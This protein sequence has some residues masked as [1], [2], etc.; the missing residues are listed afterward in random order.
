MCPFIEGAAKVVLCVPYRR[1]D[2]LD[3]LV[4]GLVVPIDEA[5]R[6]CRALPRS[7]WRAGGG[8]SARPP[9]GL[10]VLLPAGVEGAGAGSVHTTLAEGHGEEQDPHDM[11]CTEAAR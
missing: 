6:C 10:G 9:P 3:Q 5:D 11:Q 1:R 4:H 7:H 8:A 2:A